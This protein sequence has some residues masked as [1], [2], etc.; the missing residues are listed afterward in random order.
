[1]FIIVRKKQE[2]V[3]GIFPDENDI[4]NISGKDLFSKVERFWT[5]S[6]DVPKSLDDPP[7]GATKKPSV[8]VPETTTLLDD[9]PRTN[10]DKSDVA[11][12]TPISDDP[13]HDVTKPEWDVP[14]PIKVSKDPSNEVNFEEKD[15]VGI[16]MIFKEGDMVVTSVQKLI[17]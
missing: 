5:Q 17:D 16:E 3:L 11:K 6:G 15:R 2:Q 10:D 7:D 13:P 4:R 1:M 14:E 12:S 9:P 8:D